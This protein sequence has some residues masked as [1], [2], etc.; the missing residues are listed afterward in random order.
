MTTD[1]P[2][3]ARAG[4]VA[5]DGQVP[6]WIELL[7]AGPAIQGQ[8][9]RA[10]T[11]PDPD[12]VLNAFSA[13]HHPLVVDWEHASE[14]RAPNG[15]DAPAAGWIDRLEVR[16]GAVWG[17]VEWTEKAAAQIA[18]REY[19]FLSPVFIYEKTGARIVALTSAG[20]TNQPNLPLTALNREE[21]MASHPEELYTELG[22]PVGSDAAAVLASVRA[23]NELLAAAKNR[24]DTPP[25]EKFVPRADY[26]V[27]LARATNAENRL[28]EAEKAQRQARIAALIERALSERKIAPATADY[29]TAMCG[30]EGGIDQFETFLSKAPALLGGESAPEG[31]PPD[32]TPKA[33]NRAAFEALSPAA[34]KDHLARG[35]RI[36]D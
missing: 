11:L 2:V 33:I 9:G 15:L 14:H 25:L 13:R 20:L 21:P 27:V 23:L 4:N 35:G 3:F 6:D 29:Y 18:A 10:W 19:R 12:V 17:R 22:L 7:P 34:R 30:Y 24:A 32:A 8:D 26:D 1:R 31:A 28:A 16:D 5:L 36:T